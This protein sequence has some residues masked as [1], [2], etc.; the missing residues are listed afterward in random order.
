MALIH[1]VYIVYVYHFAV[2]PVEARAGIEPA[3]RA[4]AERCVTTSPPGHFLM[5]LI[6]R[7][8]GKGSPSHFAIVEEELDAR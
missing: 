3:H 6:F 2:S 1:I 7:E 5:I 8:F 4:F